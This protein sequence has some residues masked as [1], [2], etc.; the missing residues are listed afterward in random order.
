VL[1]SLHDGFR[2]NDGADLDPGVHL[3]AR[4]ALT[5]ATGVALRARRATTATRAATTAAATLASAARRFLGTHGRQA[6]GCRTMT[7]LRSDPGGPMTLR[8]V[9]AGVG[10]TG[11]ASLQLALQQLLGGRCYHM[12]ETFG[13]PNDVA[14]WHAAAK[15]EPPDWSAFL[16]EFVAA[17]DWPTCAFWR[18]LSIANP[19]AIVLLSTRSTADVWWK[20]ANDTIFQVMRR[21]F[22]PDREHADVIRAQLAMIDDVLCSTFTPQWLEEDPAKRAYD[23]HNAAVRAD[24][25]PARLVEW[26]PGDGWEPICAALD[27]PMPDEPFPH[28]NSTADFLAMIA[29]N[30]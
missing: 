4:A 2:C 1:R 9:G 24:A 13:R 12:G 7:S 21:P 11:T 19:D 8:V 28:V 17:V 3:G 25:D 18:E 20:S 22:D 5:P 10:R 23:A 14:V 6:N 30:D 16:D 27:L 29:G 15:G 26:Q